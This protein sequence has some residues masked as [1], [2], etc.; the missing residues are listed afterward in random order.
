MSGKSPTPLP[1]PI[2][3]ETPGNRG[4]YAAS[5]RKAPRDNEP[6]DAGTE[7]GSTRDSDAAAPDSRSRTP[8]PGPRKDTP[9]NGPRDRPG[10]RNATASEGP[11]SNPWFAP[12]SRPSSPPS[13][14][15]RRSIPSPRPRTGGTSGVPTFRGPGP[16]ASSA[17]ARTGDTQSPPSSSPPR[18]ATRNRAHWDTPGGRTSDTRSSG[19]G[20]TTANPS[21]RSGSPAN[22]GART[23]SALNPW[24]RT[25]STANP[26]ERTGR[27]PSPWARTSSTANPAERT[28]TPNPDERGR[29][30]NP[31]PRPRTGSP[32]EHAPTA[33]PDAR[34]RTGSRDPRT[35]SAASPD[36]RTRT[37][38][39]DSRTASTPNPDARTA[40]TPAPP[41]ALAAP[42]PGQSDSEGTKTRGDTKKKE[43]HKDSAIVR[44]RP[45]WPEVETVLLPSVK[46]SEEAEEKNAEA[47]PP[48]VRMLRWRRWHGSA[49]TAVLRPVPADPAAPAEPSKPAEPAEPSE[50]S[51]ESPRR[52]WLFRG[53]LAVILA[54]QAALSLHM[55]NTAF[56]TEA[57]YLYSGHLEIEHWLHG[58]ALQ[59]NYASFF[60]GAP[61]LYPALAAV[62]NHVGGLAA[63]RAVSL[64]AMLLTT[65]LLYSL[66]RRLF[67]EKVGV[68]AAG[69]FAASESAIFLGHLATDDAPALC[70]LAIAS[71]IV[72]R[73]AAIRWPAYLFAAPVAAL[74]VTTK[75]AALLFLPTIAVLAALAALPRVGR[76]AL[77]RP[78]AFAAV[79]AGL[80]AGA[81]N[82]GGHVYL[83]ALKITTTEYPRGTTPLLT[84]L[85][86]SALWGGLPIAL[87]LAGAAAYAWRARNERGEAIAPAGNTL[88]RTALGAVL[89]VTALLV[90]LYQMHLHTDAALDEHIGFG[91]FF[92][93]PVAGVGLARVVGDY[94]R[95]A[96]LGI[97]VWGA[98]L[99]L[100][101]AQASGLFSAWPDSAPLV[102]QISKY[103][104]P[105]AHYLVEGDPA[106]IY[107]LQGHSDAQ[108]DQFI[109]T[110]SYT[111]NQGDG[112][113]SQADC[114]DAI[115][116]G[117]F[118]LVA[119][120]G[121]TT[122]SLDS[123]IARTLHANPDY[124]LVAVVHSSNDNATYDVWVRTTRAPAG[125][126]ARITPSV[127]VGDHGGA[128]RGV[129]RLVDKDQAAGHPV[130][131]V[132][133]AEHWLGQPQRHSPDLVQAELGGRFVPV[134]SVHV[135]PVV[136]VADYRFDGPGRVLHDQPA[137]WR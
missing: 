92:A 49:N 50:P 62:A 127:D 10:T 110:A 47:D 59:G 97:V 54:G 87:A 56:S 122:P 116:S 46:E 99:A 61:I 60:S 73:T 33:N 108:P 81:L 76:W 125:L 78:V 95:R 5:H 114:V 67:N 113:T 85:R 91:L 17:N 93:G 15:T 53:V 86:E 65:A 64:V 8:D 136:Q 119:Y 36:E 69:I 9:N 129:S 31:G 24:A 123:V 12:A 41:T 7:S 115:K 25:S 21:P 4:R 105:G 132:R 51:T 6:G 80:L 63:A 96:Q 44:A 52:T 14:D 118:R 77:I 75:Y 30:P 1:P 94:L 104:Q 40:S 109:D 27:P 112:L 111:G 82:L 18:P 23:S 103:L 57:Q 83:H 137:A 71:W 43:R 128:H 3:P 135:Q 20:G 90:P 66:T 34:T 130:P 88:R 28:R 35:R 100:G 13:P 55:N 26:A 16:G 32:D 58:T 101:M 39:P 72:V 38:S 68:C 106:P 107:Y 84:I 89:A 42:A 126:S 2:P 48:T 37:G 22:P 11:T 70:L 121:D 45:K 131:R 29:T 117:Y 74:A 134:Q 133:V 98:A 19:T 124:R 120:D 79:V 102:T